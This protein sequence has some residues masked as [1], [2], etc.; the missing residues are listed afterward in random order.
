M[1]LRWPR[2]GAPLRPA[3]IP[4]RLDATVPPETRGRVLSRWIRDGW[5]PPLRPAGTLLDA[6]QPALDVRRSLGR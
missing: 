6:R 2:D 4:A 3:D 5:Q 1:T